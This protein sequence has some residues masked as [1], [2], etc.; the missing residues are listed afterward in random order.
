VFA[1]LTN[2]RDYLVGDP[3]GEGQGLG[4]VRTALEKIAAWLGSLRAMLLSP[5]WLCYIE[6]SLSRR[7]WMME[8]IFELLAAIPWWAW[9]LIVF[10]FAW[11]EA[12]A[13]RHQRR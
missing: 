7:W 9:L 8:K 12:D 6:I 5:C 13:E 10:V 3:F 11:F 4:F 1:S 2:C